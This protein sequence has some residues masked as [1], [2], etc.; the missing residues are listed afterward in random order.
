LFCP[1]FLL[2]LAAREYKKKL[3]R[4]EDES[5]EDENN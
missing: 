3:A 1:G 2:S 4:L 5:G